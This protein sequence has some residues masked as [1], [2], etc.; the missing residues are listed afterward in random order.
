VSFK[1]GN[2]DNRGK[3]WAYS[4]ARGMNDKRMILLKSR[5]SAA[6]TQE[7]GTL[8]RRQPFRAVASSSAIASRSIALARNREGLDC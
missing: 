1:T 2:H 4:T 5:Y 3:A 8:P 7:A 6:A